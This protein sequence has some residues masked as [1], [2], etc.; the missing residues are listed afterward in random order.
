M[1]GSSFASGIAW[2]NICRVHLTLLQTKYI[3]TGPHGLKFCPF[4]AYG[5]YLL[6]WQPE[7]KS[8]QPRNFM[9]PYPVLENV[10]HEI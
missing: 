5:N 8:N 3:S 6:P 1:D 10:L 7:F 9:Q 2:Q 4:Y